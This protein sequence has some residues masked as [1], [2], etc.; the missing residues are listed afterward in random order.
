MGD[1]FG[2][3]VKV[4]TA[5]IPG[6][7]GGI[8][9]GVMSAVGGSQAKGGV[10]PFEAI[11]QAYNFVFGGSQAKGAG[12]LL[13]VSAAPLPFSMN[14]QSANSV[15]QNPAGPF[16]GLDAKMG[17]LLKLMQQCMQMLQKMNGQGAAGNIGGAGT[18]ATGATGT[19][20]GSAQSSKSSGGGGGIS[21]TDSSGWGKLDDMKSQIDKLASSD[22]QSDQL[23]AQQMMAQMQRMFEMISKMMEQLSQMLSKSIQAWH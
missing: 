18:G 20:G 6:P 12:A 3:I 21:T 2:S 11:S 15:M 14:K 13:N 22:K 7:M 17:Q 4:A 9:G 19:N 8:V 23:K 16:Q 1:I 10:D 5:V